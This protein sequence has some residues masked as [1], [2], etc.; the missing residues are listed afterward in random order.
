[1]V[2]LNFSGEEKGIELKCFSL[3][4]NKK[5]CNSFK[6][7]IVTDILFVSLNKEHSN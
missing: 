1:M 5:T 7:Q 4:P 2:K 6:H 3:E